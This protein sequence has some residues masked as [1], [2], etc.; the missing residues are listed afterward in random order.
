MERSDQ[1]FAFPDF[2]D[3]PSGE[4]GQG[5]NITERAGGPGCLTFMRMAY[6]A[7]DLFTQ[8][9]LANGADRN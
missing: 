3:T 4:A 2:K 1:V 6:A 9:Q 5:A 7:R 8:G